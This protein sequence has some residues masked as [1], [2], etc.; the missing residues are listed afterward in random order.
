MLTPRRVIVGALLLGAGWLGG[1][2]ATS[3]T[4]ATDAGF[5]QDQMRRLDV[6]LG[7]ADVVVR[8]RIVETDGVVKFPGGVQHMP[9]TIDVEEVLYVAERPV[10]WNATPDYAELPAISPG[11]L[12]VYEARVESTGEPFQTRG[13][14]GDTN[15]IMTLGFW[16][17]ALYTDT[18]AEWSVNTVAVEGTDGSLTFVGRD[19]EQRRIDLAAVA[20][21]NDRLAGRDGR[22]GSDRLVDALVAWIAELKQAQLVSSPSLG[23]LET[24]FRVSRGWDLSPEDQWNALEPSD[25]YVDPETVPDSLLSRLVEATLF[26]EVPPTAQTEGWYL[27]LETPT[28]VVHRANLRG[29]SHPAPLW[30]LPG[31]EVTVFLEQQGAQNTQV[32]SFVPSPLSDTTAFD[33]LSIDAEAT[34][35]NTTL[36]E[37]SHRQL[38]RPEFEILIDAWQASEVARQSE[39]DRTGQ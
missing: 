11:P 16:D 35:A 23:P 6:V 37:A 7:G 33:V 14:Q 22:S 38:T 21:E 10:Q 30:V 18:V 5:G 32:A 9:L 19:A 39:D 36:S 31:E 34:S 27:I 3:F 17:P 20:D 4:G 1:T 28:G 24:A 8:A 15:V 26:I 13:I 29:G 12:R 2:L 25:R